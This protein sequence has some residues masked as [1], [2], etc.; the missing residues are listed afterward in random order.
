MLAVLGTAAGLERP[1]LESCKESHAFPVLEALLGGK[2]GVGMEG[3]KEAVQGV[4][5]ATLLEAK[6]YI[7]L[8]LLIAISGLSRRVSPL[9]GASPETCYCY[10]PVRRLFYRKLLGIFRIYLDPSFLGNCAELVFAEALADHPLVAH[11]PDPILEKLASC[12]AREY[13]RRRT[14]APVSRTFGKIHGFLK[15]I[16]SIDPAKTHHS[17]TFRYTPILPGPGLSAIIVIPGWLSVDMDMQQVWAGVQA[18][19]LPARVTSLVW[20]CDSV[21]SVALGG[22]V[23]KFHKACNK[24]KFT[25][26]QL[27]WQIASQAFGVG[28]VSLI[29]FSLGSRVIYYTLMELYDMAESQIYIQDVILLGGAA[30]NDPVIWSELLTQVAGRAV[31]VHS[32]NDLVLKRIYNLAMLGKPTPVGQGPIECERVENFDASSYVGGHGE[33]MTQLKRTLQ[34]IG[35][36]G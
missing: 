17:L 3:Y 11:D 12:G 19:G 36:Q 24:A 29:G 35:F 9:C 28:P 34:L 33:H 30:K 25:G 31:N 32:S 16:Y 13:E 2:E 27:A 8:S 21:V 22:V 20:D 1:W 7:A 14:S 10:T 23:T 26:R 4:R 18:F 15:R 6:C 5:A